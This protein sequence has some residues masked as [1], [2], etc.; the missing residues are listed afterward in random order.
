MA[1]TRHIDS[2]PFEHGLVVT[3]EV[4]MPVAA[5]A[6]VPMPAAGTP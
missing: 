5:P 3:D 6:A 2:L 4:A 1:D